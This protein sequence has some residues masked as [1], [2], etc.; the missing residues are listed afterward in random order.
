MVGITGNPMTVLCGRC[1][2]RVLDAKAT[3]ATAARTAGSRGLDVL[4]VAH[5]ELP[6]DCTTCAGTGTFDGF[7]ACDGCAGSGKAPATAAG[8]PPAAPGREVLP[9]TGAPP[10]ARPGAAVA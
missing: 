8:R 7:A 3:A 2:Q 1:R 6:A 9:A 4:Q 5:A 10:A